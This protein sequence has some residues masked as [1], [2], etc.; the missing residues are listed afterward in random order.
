MKAQERVHESALTI[1]PLDARRAS[2]FA[3]RRRNRKKN[4][5][6]RRKIVEN[7]KNRV[8]EWNRGA[9]S[10]K[11]KSECKNGIIAHDIW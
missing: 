10:M 1:L 3:N 5:P 6:H 2:S 4:V 9:R 11:E 8:G 7:R